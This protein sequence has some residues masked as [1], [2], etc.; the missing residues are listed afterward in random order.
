MKRRASRI[1]AL[2]VAAALCTSSISGVYACAKAA[3][4]TPQHDAQN[5]S[6]ALAAQ[7]D[8]ATLGQAFLVGLVLFEESIRATRP[9]SDCG[10]AR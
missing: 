1:R 3:S 7:S 9:C 2:A 10:G 6:D 8:L 4:Q 5:R